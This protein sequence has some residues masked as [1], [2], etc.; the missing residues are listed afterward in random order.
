MTGRTGSFTDPSP[1]NG[2][3]VG[4]G[5]HLR[6]VGQYHFAMRS[7]GFLSDEY[8]EV[9]NVLLVYLGV[10]TPYTGTEIGDS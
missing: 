1:N 4:P 9:I 5:F 7:S 3:S 6:E 10:A 8:V 2:H